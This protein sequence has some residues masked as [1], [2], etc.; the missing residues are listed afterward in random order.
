MLIHFSRVKKIEEKKDLKK[1]GFS[2][3]HDNLLGKFDWEM[4]EIFGK[5]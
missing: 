2:S 1:K 4:R 5:I 3:S